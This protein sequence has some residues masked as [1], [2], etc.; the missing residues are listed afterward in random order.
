MRRPR[1]H[2][3]FGTGNGV[4]FAQML[5]DGSAP[6]AHRVAGVP[7]LAELTSGGDVPNPLELLSGLRFER[8]VHEWRCSYEFVVIDTP[9]T[10]LFSNALAAATAVGTA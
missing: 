2:L 4:G 6:S 9:P 5:F 8:V 3:L 7:Q 10:S 1:Q